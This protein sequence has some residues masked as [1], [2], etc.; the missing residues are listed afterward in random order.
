MFCFNIYIYII[1]LSPFCF[2]II[3]YLV[4]AG[5]SF[6][7]YLG[8]NFSQP[9]GKSPLKRLLISLAFKYIQSIFNI[10]INLNKEYIIMISRK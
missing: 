4:A 8:N 9:S 2:N 3:A 7:V 5:L 10:N 1:L 6:G